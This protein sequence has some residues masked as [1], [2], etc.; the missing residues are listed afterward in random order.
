MWNR[1]VVAISAAALTIALAGPA[2]ADW[3]TPSVTSTVTTGTFPMSVTLTPD[4]SRLL[5]TNFLSDNVSVLDTS[6]MSGTTLST[7]VGPWDIAVNPSG[8]RAWLSEYGSGSSGTTVAEIDLTV[9]PPVVLRRLTVANGPTGL[10][11]TPN[12][13]E[14]WVANLSV[15]PHNTPSVSIINAAA[16]PPVVVTTLA[17]MGDNPRDVAFNGDGTRALV[18]SYTGSPNVRLVDVATRTVVGS[19]SIGSALES[20]FFSADG[21]RAWVAGG[22][23]V[24]LLSISGNSVTLI[25]SAASSGAS[26]VALS[27]EGGRVWVSNYF[28]STVNF[29]DALTLAPATGSPF[30]VGTNPIGI[31]FTASGST[32]YVANSGSNNLSVVSTG[33]VAGGGDPSQYPTAPEQAFQVPF[34]TKASECGALAPD[35]VD[36]PG[37]RHL[38]AQ[39]WAISYAE[40]PNDHQGGWVCTRQPFWNGVGWAIR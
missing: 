4:E 29:F 36:W 32:A 9:S 14:V 27:P 37:I 38:H 28:G 15:Y 17:G 30:T 31:A 3:G 12:G 7:N 2:L 40:W 18:I 1:G 11:V 35:S 10:A 16:T 13:S 22:N 39:G 26:R 24:Y 33:W 5:V 19:L 6:S 20:V 8:T 23:H 21:T 25:A 34:D